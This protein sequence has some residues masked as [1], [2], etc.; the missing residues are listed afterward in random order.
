MMA[1]IS[2]GECAWSPATIF[3]RAWQTKMENIGQ[4]M[5]LS[6]LDEEFEMIP[7]NFM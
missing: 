1:R 4:F 2:M 6:K 3:I 7:I 5:W